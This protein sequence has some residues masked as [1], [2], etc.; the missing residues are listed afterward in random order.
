MIFIVAVD[1][2]MALMAVQGIVEGSAPTKH[3]VRVDWFRRDPGGTTIF[4][5][6][7]GGDGAAS[8]RESEQVR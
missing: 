4:V 2:G 7:A 8:Q 1:E 5:V 3:S 6:P